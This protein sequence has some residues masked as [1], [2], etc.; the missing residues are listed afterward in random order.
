MYSTKGWPTMPIGDAGPPWARVRGPDDGVRAGG[1]HG[2]GGA[3]PH[4]NPAAMKGRHTSLS[5]LW[6]GKYYFFMQLH[7]KFVNSET[8]SQLKLARETGPRSGRSSPP[9][10]LPKRQDRYIGLHFC[11]PEAQVSLLRF[12]CILHR[13]PGA[14]ELFPAGPAIR[15]R[16]RACVYP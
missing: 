14:P 2:G 11:R 9:L 15:Q 6:C 1:G 8:L 16:S 3:I 13:K 5:Q 10:F 4:L 12:R 7:K